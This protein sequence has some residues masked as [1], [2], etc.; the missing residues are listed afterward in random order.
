METT[1]RNKEN[2]YNEALKETQDSFSYI[3]EVNNYLLEIVN[4][5]KTN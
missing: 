3:K 4:Q 1:E 5:I 2:I